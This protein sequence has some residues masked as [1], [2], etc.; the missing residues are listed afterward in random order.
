MPLSD[1]DKTAIREMIRDGIAEAEAERR[2]IRPAALVGETGGAETEYLPT[3]AK[4]KEIADASVEAAIEA[5]KLDL[6][7]WYQINRRL[8]SASALVVVLLALAGAIYQVGKH[9]QGGLRNLVHWVAGTE[10]MVKQVLA[11]DKRD[12]DTDDTFRSVTG[13]AFRRWAESQPAV[14]N[15]IRTFVKKA[16]EASPVLVFQG[17]TTFS[18]AERINKDCVDFNLQLTSALTTPAL[19]ASAQSRAPSHISGATSIDPMRIP[20]ACS[21]DAAAALDAPLD[22]PFFA[23]VYDTEADG[24]ADTIFAILVM[25]REPKED[26]GTVAVRRGA[27]GGPAG[28][29]V[30]YTTQNPQFRIDGEHKESL[31][32]DEAMVESGAGSDFWQISLSEAIAPHFGD[33]PPAFHLEQILHSV[34]VRPITSPADLAGDDECAGVTPVDDQIISVRVLVFVNKDV[35]NR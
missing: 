21:N 35:D 14:D 25:K 27:N 3:R 33:R 23:R 18:L 11:A 1:A 12:W 17:Q 6:P 22:V 5:Y 20:K 13:G 34:N 32:L 28:V 7:K 31:G 16:L 2:W 15:P 26:T 9:D 29:C 8:D 24:P 10:A 4:A 19:P 30:S